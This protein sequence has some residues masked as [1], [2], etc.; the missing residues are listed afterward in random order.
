MINLQDENVIKIR[1]SNF[2]PIKDV[3][4][5]EADPDK[6][7]KKDLGGGVEIVID[8]AFYPHATDNVTQDGIVRYV[9]ARLSSGGKVDLAPGDHVYTHHFLC[10]LDAK[11]IINDKP[12]QRILHELI[13]CKIVDGKIQMLTPYSLVEPIY[14]DESKYITKSGIYT[15][16]GPGKEPRIGILKHTNDE[17]REMGAK[18]GDKICFTEVADYEMWIEGILYYRMKNRDVL[19]LVV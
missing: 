14:E 16:P 15:K 2:L 8:T 3:V 6:N 1:S 4:Y 7:K 19:G 17:L 11:V 10:D 13:Y 9:P 5:V 12:L 18:E